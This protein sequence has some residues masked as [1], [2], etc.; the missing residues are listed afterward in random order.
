MEVS[1]LWL[2]AGLPL[3]GFVCSVL[4]GI[5]GNKK[6]VFWLSPAVILLS[7]ALGLLAFIQLLP[8]KETLLHQDLF[9]WISVNSF[10]VNVNFEVNRL[11]ALFVLIITGVGFLIHV[12]SVG[13]LGAT[14]GSQRFFAYL[15]LFVFFMLVLV[16]ADNLLLLFV[17]WEGVGLSSY[18]L[19]SYEHQ[20]EV[21]AS[22]AKKAFIFNRVG[23]VGF[24]IAT[25]L[26]FWVFGSLDF[27]VLNSVVQNLAVD[28]LVLADSAVANIVASSDSAPLATNGWIINTIVLLFMLAAAGKSAQIPLYVWLPDAMEG[29]TPVSA[30]IHAATMVT[31]GLYLLLRLNSLLVLAPFAMGIIAGIGA[32]TALLAATIALVQYDIKKVLAYSTVSQLGYMF[33]A[34]GVGAFTASIFHVLTH[35]F[36]KA[37]LFLAAG[38]VIY[39][40]HHQQDMRKMGGL[41]RYMPITGITYLIGAL[42]ISGFPFFFAGFFSKDEILWLAYTSPLGGR[43]LWAVGALTAILTAFYMFRSVALTLLG[44]P[45]FKAEV[46][47][48][49][50][51]MT[52][53]LLCLAVLSICGGWI[54]IPHFLGHYFHL[55]NWLAGYFEGFFSSVGGEHQGEASLEW[56]LTGITT[57][58][59]L[60]AMLLGGLFFS[61]WLPLTTTINNRF[62]SITLLLHKKYYLDQLYE[63]L[64]IKPLYWISKQLLW[65]TIDVRLVDGIVGSIGRGARG[66]G[67]VLNK[68]QT[69]LAQTYLLAILLGMLVL[70]GLAG[71]KWFF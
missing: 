47:E 56:L 41:L 52:I 40:M 33:M 31:A 62:G 43:V 45:R 70:V 57:G 63:V 39:G 36:F 10:Q 30:L 64:L 50:K 18:L 37:L 15:N 20:R 9:N 46:K 60:S 55:P 12:Y 42:A 2:I 48:S 13:Y 59:A 26:V 32:I 51:C 6:L 25:F 22:A 14:A 23:D 27:S 71:G 49:P 65:K 1:Y 58:L 44:K 11:S 17:G 5:V 35:A 7:F 29:P 53:P 8:A 68:S 16:L 28:D 3:A 4:L 19:I 54:G 34:I 38:S 21:A 24:V 66:L 69:G 67:G 61:R